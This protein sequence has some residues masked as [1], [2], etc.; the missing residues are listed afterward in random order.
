[1]ELPTAAAGCPTNK[2]IKRFLELPVLV[3][4]SH[5]FPHFLEQRESR[6]GFFFIVKSKQ[7]TAFTFCLLSLNP[8]DP[9]ACFFSF[10]Q[11]KTLNP[12]E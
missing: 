1:M 8:E 12:C 4:H 11:M 5:D 6:T 10:R 3:N 2:E 7:K 9:E